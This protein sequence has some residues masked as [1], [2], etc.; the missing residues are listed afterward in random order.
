MLKTKK[1]DC[2]KMKQDIQT[3]ILKE[4]KGVP[5]EQARQAKRRQIETDPAL[6]PFLKRLRGN[7]R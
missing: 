5:D 1:F 7:R 3:S 2:V 6:G 4:F